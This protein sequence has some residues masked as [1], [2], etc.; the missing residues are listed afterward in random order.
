MANTETGHGDRS[1]GEVSGER[2]LVDDETA[3]GE[4]ERRQVMGVRLFYV[5]PR[6][7]QK[8]FFS[9]SGVREV[10]I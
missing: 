2:T 6:R 1:G 7:E 9:R 3:V 10:L 4:L 8:R 5:G